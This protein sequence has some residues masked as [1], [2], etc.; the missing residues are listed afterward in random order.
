M[1]YLNKNPIPEEAILDLEPVRKVNLYGY[2]P[3]DREKDKLYLKINTAIPNVVAPLRRM[4]EKEEKVCG[5][6][7]PSKTF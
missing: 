4:F 1:D 3:K 5:I 6:N 2:V 7:L